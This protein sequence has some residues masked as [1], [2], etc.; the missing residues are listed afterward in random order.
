MKW[1]CPSCGK[2]LNAAASFTRENRR[3]PEPGDTAICAYCA[4]VLTIVD[5]GT[6]R[7]MSSAEIKQRPNGEMIF[8]V[9]LSVM[10]TIVKRVGG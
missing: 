5:Q 1:N 7:R 9:Q 8:K 2:M 6:V 3:G 10:A 4:C